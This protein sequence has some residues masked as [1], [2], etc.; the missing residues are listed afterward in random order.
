MSLDGKQKNVGLLGIF[1][2]IKFQYL[3]KWKYKRI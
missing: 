1:P 2:L 3:N